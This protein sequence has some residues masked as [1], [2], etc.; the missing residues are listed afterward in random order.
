MNNHRKILIVLA[1]LFNAISIFAQDAVTDFVKINEFFAN[2]QKLS[3][4]MVYTLYESDISDKILEQTTGLMKQDS[5]LVYSMSDSMETI[6]NIDYSVFVDNM[7][8]TISISKQQ[9]AERKTKVSPVE[10]SELLKL[11]SDV[12][13]K[14]EN[15]KQASYTLSFEQAEYTKIVIYFNTSTFFTDKFVFFFRDASILEEELV[16]ENNNLNKNIKREEKEKP[17]PRLEMAIK[18]LNTKPVF[19]KETFT[20]DSYLEIKDGKFIGKGKYADYEV[21]DLY[22][23]MSFK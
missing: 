17:A 6:S 3:F 4:N 14:K 18:N 11:C 5:M 2:H 19:T 22:T 1:V 21:R 20:Y 15:N 13:Y 23:N 16:V 9:L 12:K 10:I 8:K 7:D